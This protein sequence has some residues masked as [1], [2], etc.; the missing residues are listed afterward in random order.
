MGPEAGE[1]MEDLLPQPAEVGRRES[2]G[3]SNLRQPS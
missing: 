2:V 3:R 1:A